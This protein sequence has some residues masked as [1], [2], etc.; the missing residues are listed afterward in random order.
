MSSSCPRSCRLE[1]IVQR[2]AVHYG[3]HVDIRPALLAALGAHAIRDLT[4]AEPELEDVIK[5]IYAG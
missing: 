3:Y 5:R 4:V 2:A 1:P